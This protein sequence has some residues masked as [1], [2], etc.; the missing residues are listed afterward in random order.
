MVEDPIEAME[1]TRIR[2]VAPIVHDNAYRLS[3]LRRAQAFGH[4]GGESMIARIGGL[5]TTGS[6]PS[7]LQDRLAEIRERKNWRPVQLMER[8]RKARSCGNEP[9]EPAADIFAYTAERAVLQL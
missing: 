5:D 4:S 6:P 3:A 8:H 7:E 1:I 2:R 9:A